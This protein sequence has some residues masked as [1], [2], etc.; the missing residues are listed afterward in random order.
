MSVWRLQCSRKDPRISVC[1]YIG[2][3]LLVQTHS[4][5][6]CK[7]PSDIPNVL[8]AAWCCGADGWQVIGQ[9]VLQPE[10][11]QGIQDFLKMSDKTRQTVRKNNFSLMRVDSL[12]PHSVITSCLSTNGK[13][14]WYETLA[15][16]PTRSVFIHI[17]W[18]GTSCYRIVIWLAMKTK[19]PSTQ[20]K[21]NNRFMNCRHCIAL[22]PGHSNHAWNKSRQNLG[23][24]WERCKVIL[25]VFHPVLTCLENW[26]HHPKIL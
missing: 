13:G 15:R 2:Q 20:R 21:S 3:C 19:L 26:Y 11:E 22:F 14:S 16:F 5:C 18:A 6:T 4:S 10:V 9:W 25:P 1:C 8:Q 7:F 24:A 12:H 17:W 23:V